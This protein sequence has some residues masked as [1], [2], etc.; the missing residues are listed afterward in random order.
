MVADHANPSGV[1][2]DP[3]DRRALLD[4]TGADPLAF[5]GIGTTGEMFDVENGRIGRRA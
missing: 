2:L 4:T 5:S 3:A 1:S